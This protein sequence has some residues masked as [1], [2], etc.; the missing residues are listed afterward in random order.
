MD[1]THTIIREVADLEGISPEELPSIY[2]ALDPES[3]EELI[4]SANNTDLKIQFTY[5]GYDIYIDE[6]WEVMVGQ[7]DVD[8]G[9]NGEADEKLE[10]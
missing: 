9:E 5:V 1:L 3:L 2:N 7:N 8:V 6:S 10:F 4:K